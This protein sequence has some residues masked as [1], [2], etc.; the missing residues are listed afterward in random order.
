MSKIAWCTGHYTTEFTREKAKE[1][2]EKGYKVSFGSYIRENG[3][4]YC[5]IYLEMDFNY[6]ILKLLE[7]IDTKINVGMWDVVD[8]VSSEKNRFKEMCRDFHTQAKIVYDSEN[9]KVFAVVN[10]SYELSI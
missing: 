3:K 6:H 4:S 7:S 8:A 5:K 10:C 1:L 9:R 2:R